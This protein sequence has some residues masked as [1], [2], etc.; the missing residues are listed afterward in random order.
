MKLLCR[1]VTE[2]KMLNGLLIFMLMLC[3]PNL[4][5]AQSSLKVGWEPAAPY[6]YLDSK[7]HLTGLDIE[8][9]S[10]IAK[11]VNVKLEFKKILWK[12]LL[13]E[14]EQGTMD[15]A[16]SAT[17][18]AEREKFAFFSDP[19][20]K[21]VIVLFVRRGES[22]KYHFKTLNDL[23]GSKFRLGVTS[24]NFYGKSFDLLM[25][26]PTFVKQTEEAS[27][28][29]SN[30]QKLLANKIDGFLA[31]QT[32]TVIDIRKEGLNGKMDIYPMDITTEDICFIFS[33]KSVKPDM[34]G[35]FNAG[36]KA[37]KASGDYDKIINKFTK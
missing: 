36:L 35:T 16:L 24:G 26:N 17:K 25:K 23:V 34:V 22:E 7:G 3:G 29:L 33:R 1:P 32:G 27:D 13:S 6:Q 37:L 20:R 31:D 5:Q 4:V 19:Y 11:K 30:Y 21:E 10:A 18:T 14:V 8:L 2:L 28:D 15:I 9:F 12:K